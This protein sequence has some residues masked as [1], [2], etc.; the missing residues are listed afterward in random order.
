MLKDLTDSYGILVGISACIGLLVGLSVIAFLSLHGSI[1]CFT[2]AFIGTYSWV[3]IIIPTV[4]LGTSYLVVRFLARA[5]TTGCGTHH[6]LEV[7]HYEGGIISGR[8]TAG[9]TLASVLTIGLGGS[10]GLEGPSLLLGGGIA[11]TLCQRLNI[12]REQLKLYLLAGAAAGVSAVFKAPLT[13]IL[14]ALEIPY[15]RDLA[16]EAFIPA[17]VSSI[18][19]Y[20]T[21]AGVLGV[22]ILFPPILTLV[23]PSVSMV[24]HSFAIGLIAVLCGVF[25]I[26]VYNIF[27][28]LKS[29]LNASGLACALVGG[30]TLGVIGLCVPQVLGIGYDTIRTMAT[31][32]F[33]E[34]PPGFLASL[35]IFKALA[36]SIT[37][38]TG[39]SGGLFI[40][41]I[42]VGA[43]LGALYSKAVLQTFSEVVVMAAMAATIAVTNKTLLTS[44]AFVAETVGP[45]SV[46]PTLVAAATSYFVSGTHSFYRYVQPI[47]RPVEE[48]EAVAMLFHAAEKNKSLQ[49]LRGNKVSDLMTPDPVALTENMNICEAIDTIREHS[50]RAYPIVTQDGV[51]IG[52]TTLEDL[53]SI[54]VEK[55]HLSVGNTPVRR[56]LRVRKED[57]LLDVVKIMLDERVDHVYVVSDIHTMKLVGVIAGIDIIRKLI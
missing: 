1:W 55:R 50:F 11:S 48:E 42:Y 25:F 27:G 24:L 51:L 13:G 47:E 6:F 5:K 43:V 18:T 20:F 41:S 33:Y 7:Y 37:L 2:S 3:V 34:S 35:I 44:V 15:Q 40:P 10:A 45:S 12:R 21:L 9:K 39:G 36:T 56:A 28:R 26:E 23:T 57:A 38:N 29:W 8:D 52:Y 17:T 16:V 30:V 53:L 22:E 31:G 19:A 49:N 54:P 14:F 4:G 46:I 32:E